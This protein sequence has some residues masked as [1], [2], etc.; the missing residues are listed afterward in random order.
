MVQYVVAKIDSLTY[1]LVKIAEHTS[2]NIVIPFL[3]EY[4]PIV[5]KEAAYEAVEKNL[6]GSRPKELFQVRRIP[7]MVSIFR[8]S[9]MELD[10]IVAAGFQLDLIMSV[11]LPRDRQDVGWTYM[12]NFACS[13]LTKLPSVEIAALHRPVVRG[14]AA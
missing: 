8:I 7:F 4:Q 6:S 1:F 13:T 5:R 2:S 9:R 3:Q 14:L 11:A 10:Q 12:S